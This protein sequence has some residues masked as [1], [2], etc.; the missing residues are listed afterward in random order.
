MCNHYRE[1]VGEK[2][3]VGGGGCCVGGGSVLWSGLRSI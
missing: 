1:R 2:L 3:G